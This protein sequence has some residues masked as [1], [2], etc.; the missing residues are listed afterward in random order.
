MKPRVCLNMI[1]KNEAHVIERCLTSVAPYIDSWLIV[2]TGSEDDTRERI[3]GFFREAQRPGELVQRPWV[4][5]GTNRTE[6]LE[7]SRKLGDYSLVIDAD[8]VL[9]VQPGFKWPTLD[10]DAYEFLHYH[11]HTDTSFHLLQMV[12][13]QKPFRYAGVLHEVMVCDAPFSRARMPGA[14]IRG[15]FDSARNQGDPKAKYARDAEVFE[16]AL[17]REPDNARYVFYL[18]Q[19]YR[20]SGQIEKAVEAYGRRSKM[21]GFEEEAWYAELMRA[22]LLMRLGQKDAAVL[23]YL[24][25][26]QRRPTRAETLVDLAR[27]HREAKDYHLAYLFASAAARIKPSDD[28][29][30]VER[31]AYGYRA[32]DELAVAAY[33]VGQYQQCRDLCRGLLSGREIPEADRARVQKNLEFSL[34]KLGEG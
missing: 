10:H 23:A 27:L 21:G 11:G 3:V 24:S 2:D 19:S 30:F 13:T 18:G 28:I 7:L 32:A 5:F 25:A 4:D 9:E 17:E 8:E 16:R 14:A 6:A 26:Y 34:Q 33:W 12:R 31:A 29:L 15:L 1:V 22:R 20:D